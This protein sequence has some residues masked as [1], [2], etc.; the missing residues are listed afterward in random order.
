M[1]N[2][3]FTPVTLGT[4][5]LANRVVMAPMTRSRAVGN[6]PNAL[7]AKYYADRAAAGLIVTEGVAPSADGLGYARIPGLFTDAQERGWKAVTDAVHRAGGRIFAQLMHTGRVGHPANMPAGSRILA[8][9]AIAAPGQMWTDQG[10]LQDHPAPVEMTEADIAKAIGEF[11]A[12]AQRAVAAGFDGVELHGANGYLV[13]QFLNTASNRRT[14]RWG[15]SV[16][17]RM[18]FAVEV[19]KATAA[20]IG[21]GRVGIRLSPYNDFNGMAPD[22][23]MDGLYVR[24]A[25]EMGALGIAYVHGVDHSSMGATGPRAELKAAIR[26]AFTGRFILSGGYDAARAAADLEAGRGDLVAFARPFISNPDL[27]A[28][29][30]RGA[31]LT[32]ADPATFYTPG[33]KG[34]TDYPAGVAA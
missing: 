30:A 10:G 27:V 31:A 34:Y 2:K 15:G 13:D 8:P 14:D 32:P 17:N 7:M 29:L 3:L 12:A 6:V 20:A 24:L 16:E 11:A 33:E 26:A 25:Q 18:R 9:S 21:A 1:T 19:A 23:G 5:T 4:L 22:A 28:K